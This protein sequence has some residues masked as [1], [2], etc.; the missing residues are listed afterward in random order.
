MEEV[1]RVVDHHGLV[2]YGVVF[3][4]DIWV[5]LPGPVEGDCMLTKGWWGH[6][7]A[8]GFDSE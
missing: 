6:D 2:G 1:G 3:D 4:E 5:L 8:L 7:F